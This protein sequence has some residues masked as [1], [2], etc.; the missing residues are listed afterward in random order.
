M[1]DPA[2]ALFDGEAALVAVHSSPRVKAC[3]AGLAVHPRFKDA[4]AAANGD[5]DFWSSDDDWSAEFRPYVVK[6]GILQIPIKGMLLH[7]FP[8][9]FGNWATG[10]EYIYQAF[11]RGVADYMIGEVYGIALVIDSP[12]GMVA[13]CF[14]NIDKCYALK[15]DS[16]VPV[17]AFAHESAYSAAYGWFSLADKGTVSR[18]GGV[19]SIGVVTM[20]VDVSEAIKDA[21]YKITFIHA[22]KHKVDGNPYEPLKPEVEA[23]IQAR[24]DELYEIF[25]ANVAR[26]RPQ[27]TENVI[28]ETEALTYTA[29]EALSIGLADTIGTL[30]DALAAF[31]ANTASS[32]DEQMAN[33]PDAAAE[34]QAAIDAAV[35]AARAEN[36][37]AISA[38]VTAERDR[39]GAILGS[40]EA[41]G[42]ETQAH[43]IAFKSAMTVD[44]AKAMLGASAKVEVTPPKTQAE[45]GADF[46]AAMGQTPNVGASVDKGNDTHTSDDDASAITSLAALVG[47]KGFAKKSN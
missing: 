44:E 42:R 17:Q 47:L 35:A 25:V 29:T 3:L 22:G 16:G 45:T 14:D 31:A 9:A 19:G 11:K 5:D 26:N 20:H 10:Y 15:Q 7:N 46:D 13:G 27:L 4:L 1:H 30:E 38:A 8:Y 18:T 39:I 2:F 33:T 37:T 41:K 24:I 21:G 40:D 12:G 43:F 28:R 32:G 6:D 34:R 36:A 23:R